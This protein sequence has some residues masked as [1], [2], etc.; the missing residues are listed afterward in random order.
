MQFGQ[1]IK[2]VM[3]ALVLLMLGGC[4][5]EPKIIEKEK[6]VEKERIE[7]VVVTQV[8]LTRAILERLSGNL[9]KTQNEIIKD[10]QL[11]ISGRITLEIDDIESKDKLDKGKPVLTDI[12]KRIIREVKPLTLGMT[13]EGP[14]VEGS[15]RIIKVG[16]EQGIETNLMVFAQLGEDR[17]FYLKHDSL[18]AITG[19]EKGTI[20]YGDKVYK[21][22]YAE[23]P[24]LLIQ[25]DQKYE[26]DTDY[27]VIKGWRTPPGI[28]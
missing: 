2:T 13:R 27:E 16:F 10:C 7:K 18:A 19:N 28:P 4:A 8:P 25:I 14:L 17:Y 22:K 26:E 12:Y 9:G 3:G 5:G 24:Y 21:I 23:R 15:E 1:L 11:Y 20:K 6:I